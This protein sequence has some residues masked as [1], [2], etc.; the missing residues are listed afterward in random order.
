MTWFRFKACVKCRGDLV[1]DE[2][3]WLCLQ[4][5][6]YYYVGLYQRVV[7]RDPPPFHVQ[8]PNKEK[9]AAPLPVP[10]GTCGATAVERSIADHQCLNTT[11][12][13]TVVPA[14][15]HVAW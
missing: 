14:P 15:A 11:A 2:G 6:R 12:K 5:G 13:E 10:V 7:S 8:T 1:L 3:D 4:C 9:A